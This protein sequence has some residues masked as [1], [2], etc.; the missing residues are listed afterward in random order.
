MENTV[1]NGT[2]AKSHKNGT[3]ASPA[4]LKDAWSDVTTSVNDLYRAADTFA[5]EQTRMR[6]HVVLGVA[7]GVGFVLGGGL[8]SRLGSTLLGVGTRLVASRFLE[9][10]T[11]SK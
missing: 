4:E 3:S 5:T 11:A 9:E 8:A 1:S 7:A 2:S 6:P 10:L